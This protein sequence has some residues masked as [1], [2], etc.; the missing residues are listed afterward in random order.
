MFIILLFLRVQQQPLDFCFPPSTVL[1]TVTFYFF[2]PVFPLESSD[3]F[4]FATL[5]L[6]SLARV[7]NALSTLFADFAEVS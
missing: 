1:P 3:S 5:L 7:K 6:I 4:L 2:A